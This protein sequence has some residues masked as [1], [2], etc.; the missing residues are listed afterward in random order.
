MTH[1]AP[2]LDDPDYLRA[3]QYRDA[4]NLD[5]RARLHRKYGRGD[6]MDWVAARLPL[7]DG[8]RVLELG[9]GP[10]WLWEAVGR[11]RPGVALDLT[12]TDLS[13]GMAQEAVGRAS[14]AGT[15]QGWTVRGKVADASALPFPDAAFDLVVACHMLYHLPH[16]ALGV[17][18]IA[19]VLA[20]GGMAVVATNGAANLAELYAVRAAVW[21]GEAG[22]PVS[23]RFG[24][25]TGGPML[26]AAFEDVALERY[27]DDLEVTD[28]A[29][30]VAY[31][32]S[33]PPGA[34]ASAAQLE[35]LRAQARAAV[36][37]GGG[38]LKV[39]K[40]TGIVLCR[41]AG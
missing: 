5:A 12:L 15:A 28:P 10:G 21:P 17:A 33:S 35:S 20:P 11:R 6:W 8:T 18:E 39:S 27:D 36:T 32:T 24:I 30:L 3:V 31:L 1:T 34:D 23:W 13:P 29:D 22:D 14:A 40:D 16:P 19:R 9:C 38:K 37:H 26:E 41:K 4:S 2:R 7:R 25:E